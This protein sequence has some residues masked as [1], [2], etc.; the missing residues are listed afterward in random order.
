MI[1]FKENTVAE[2]KSFHWSVVQAVFDKGDDCHNCRYFHCWSEYHPYGNTMAQERLCECK[3][4]DLQVDE[5]EYCPGFED[6]RDDLR[7]YQG[8]E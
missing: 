7:E 8:D 5:P 4:G 2:N 6:M 3:L 1:N